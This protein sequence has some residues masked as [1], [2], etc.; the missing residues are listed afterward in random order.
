[1]PDGRE[2]W[3]MS[4]CDYVKNASYQ[5]CRRFTCRGRRR[6]CIEEQD[7]EPISY[8]LSAQVGCVK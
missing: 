1:M 4:P 6:V 7:K 2:V 5:E 8:E 3:A